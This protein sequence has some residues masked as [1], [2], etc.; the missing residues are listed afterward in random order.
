MTMSPFSRELTLTLGSEDA[1]AN[2]AISASPSSNKGRRLPPPCGL[3]NA[4]P[5]LL[6]YGFS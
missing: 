3:T 2:S 6:E 1:R 5:S 4:M